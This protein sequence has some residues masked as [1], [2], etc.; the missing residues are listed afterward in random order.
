MPQVHN[1]YWQLKANVQGLEQNQDQLCMWLAR[2][3]F[4]VG[5]KPSSEHYCMG[6][7]LLT[8]ACSDASDAEIIMITWGLY[9]DNF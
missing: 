7:L 6:K 2:L 5:D 3:F 8:E 4:A 9:H 1:L